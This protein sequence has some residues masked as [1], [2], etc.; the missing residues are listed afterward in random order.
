MKKKYD[1]FIAYHGTYSPT[2]SKV[3][4]DIVYKYL[5][6][7]GLK[8]YYF[9]ENKD[10]NFKYTIH[11]IPH[12][13]CFLLVVTTGLHTE[14]GKINPAWNFELASEVNSMYALTLQNKRSIE[15]SHV[16]ACGDDWYK[17]SECNLNDLFANRIHFYMNSKDDPL[18]DIYNW[19][20]ERNKHYK[21][22]S[23]I[24]SYGE[25]KRVFE[26]FEYAEAYYDL[27]SMVMNA[28]V[29]EVSFNRKLLRKL[30]KNSLNH[31][32][33]NKLLKVHNT[34][35]ASLR[36]DN[37]LFIELI[38]EGAVLVTGLDENQDLVYKIM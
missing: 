2:G 38:D 36:V 11:E 22:Y 20:V 13:T 10:M 34:K 24:H 30:S 33:E 23:D 7:R 26:N 14:E 15:D 27:N 19:I 1:V 3:K 28:S 21:T 29:V 37:L 6:E 31:I 4:A 5:T 17:G 32:E 12:C 35:F 8:C 25:V 16:L 9:P 18:D